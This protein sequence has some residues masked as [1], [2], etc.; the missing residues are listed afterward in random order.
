V[1]W[2]LFKLY[3]ASVLGGFAGAVITRTGKVVES[4]SPYPW[5]W[6]SHPAMRKLVLSKPVKLSGKSLLLSTAGLHDGNY[7]HFLFDFLPKFMIL[8]KAGFEAGAWDH[9]IMNSDKSYVMDSLERV[10]IGR[11][12]VCFLTDSTNIRADELYVPTFS[13]SLDGVDSWQAEEARRMYSGTG[14]NE[15]ALLYLSRGNALRRRIT[16]EAK[17]ELLLEKRGFKILECSTLSVPDQASLFRGARVVVSPHGAAL[18]NLVFCEPGTKV[19]EIINPSAVR[20]LYRSLSEVLGL[21]YLPF[22][23]KKNTRAGMPKHHLMNLDLDLDFPSFEF[24]LDEVVFPNGRN[25]AF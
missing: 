12:K 5:G 19:V 10:G 7:Y 2:D 18:A 25:N 4:C 16:H 9:V 21:D 15:G 3:E 14:S 22:A 6:R 13:G 24:F 23:A 8:R 20:L 11:K 1:G 17:L